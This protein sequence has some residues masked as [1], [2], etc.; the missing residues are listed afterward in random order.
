ML[1]NA[2]RPNVKTNSIALNAIVIK[3]Y[4]KTRQDFALANSKKKKKVFTDQEKRC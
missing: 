2:T 3:S 1:F 4:G